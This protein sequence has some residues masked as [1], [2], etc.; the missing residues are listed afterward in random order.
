MAPTPQT[1]SLRP[2]AFVLHNLATGDAPVFLPLTVRPEDLTRTD[3][4]R[5]NIA[6]TLGGAW[7][8]SWGAGIPTAQIAGTTGWGQAGQPDGFEQFQLLYDTVYT[9][10]HKE[11]KAETAKDGGDPDKVRLLYADALNGFTWVIAP[12]QFSLKR[13][14]SR[15]LLSQYQ[16]S[17]SW[18]SDDIRPTLDALRSSAGGSGPATWYDNFIASLG[19]ALVKIRNFI[20]WLSSGAAAV[21][22]PIKAAMGLFCQLTHDVLSF[23][24]SGVSAGIGLVRGITSDVINIAGNLTRA[25]GNIMRTVGTIMSVPLMVQGQINRAAQAFENCYCLLQNTT[26]ALNTVPNYHDLYGSANCS[27]TLGGSPVSAYDL[28][29]PFPAMLPLPTQGQQYSAPAWSSLNALA[30]TDPVLSPMS[31]ADILR[32]MATVN[33]GLRPP[34]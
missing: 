27:S 11:R 19:N 26:A 20:G 6:Q 1:P 18:V 4:S 34:Q 25:A 30:N 28:I 7:L 31:Q 22:G 3:G 14:K 23:V 12:Q 5:L 17:F 33:S 8:D 10:W 2:I 15:P 13:S 32:N 9:R 16:I 29:N 24:Q 21:L